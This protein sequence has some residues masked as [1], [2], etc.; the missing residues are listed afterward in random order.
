MTIEGFVAALRG[1]INQ[2]TQLQGTTQVAAGK[3]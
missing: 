2:L 3:N 1:R